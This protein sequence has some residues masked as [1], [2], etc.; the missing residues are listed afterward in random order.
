MMKPN[1]VVLGSMKCGTTSL[2]DILENHPEV[3]FSRPKEPDFFCRDEVFAQGGAWYENIFAGAQGKIAIGEGS[4][5]YTKKLLFP[6]TAERL[7]AHLPDAKFIYMVRHPLDRLVSHYKHWYAGEGYL[8]EPYGPEGFEHRLRQAPDFIDT[9]LYWKQLSQ[10]RHYY[11]DERFHIIFFDDFKR[12]PQK[13]LQDCFQFLGV[14]TDVA[15]HEPERVRNPSADRTN[16]RWL[17]ALRQFWPFQVLK[18]LFPTKTR[19]KF[20]RK[21]QKPLP[22]GYL[23]TTTSRH[24]VLDQIRD[25][26]IAFLKHCGRPVDYW[27]LEENKRLP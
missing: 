24:F 1:F 27:N 11:P 10:Y 7:A 5:S 14:R 26:L 6:K 18:S 21:I 17:P 23:W 22:S 9:G 20:L 4:T 16:P 19:Q 8:T 12:D 3:F 13:A 2:C 25:D 15:P